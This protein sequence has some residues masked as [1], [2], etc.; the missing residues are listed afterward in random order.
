MTRRAFLL[1]AAS[2][3]LLLLSTCK[4][5]SLKV[6]CQSDSDCGANFRC[7][8]SGQ[9]GGDCVCANNQACPPG[10]AGPMFCNPQGLC[11]SQVGCFSNLDCT[12]SGLYCDTGVG[13]C[14]TWP[15]CGTD[16]DCPLGQVC[17]NQLC[18]AGCRSNGD[19]PLGDAG[20]VV[21]C[22]CSGG[23][24]CQC[25]PPSDAGFVDPASYDRSLCPIGACNPNSCAG[26][27]A[28]CPY[29]ESCVA[30]GDGG[31][32]TCQSDSRDTVLC[33]NCTYSPGSL[34]SGCTGVP[35]ANF[36]LLDLSN[37][38]GGTTFCGVDCSGGQ[39]CPSGYECDDVI[40]LTSSICTSDLSCVPTGGA[41]NATG[42]D[43]GS[44]GC[45]VDTICDS[46][47]TQSTGRCGGFCVKAEGE[48]AGFCT[49]VEDS[50]CPQDTCDTT[51]RTCTISQKPCNPCD[52]ATCNSV[53]SCVDFG[54]A[55]GC[56]I[57][58]NCAP[59]HGLHCPLPGQ[60]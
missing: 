7:A 37:P 43:G 48:T 1:A 8:N 34:A 47:G 50:D 55:R 31:L 58:R 20:A 40:I 51:A 41:C 45:P 39:G 3:A 32:S 52:T 59:T 27:T 23:S 6:A 56:W 38:S 57:G 24:E 46:V 33:Q 44:T 60:Q 11:Q 26:D 19:C 9:F 21:P 16:I 12:A 2:G 25:P 28:V 53:V 10:D 29:N 15:A 17:S 13:L 30:G 14:V 42:A 35:G 5:T 49:C 36:C 18:V 54:G 4:N 22:V